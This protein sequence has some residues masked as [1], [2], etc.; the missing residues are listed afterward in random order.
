[1]NVNEE[2]Y[3]LAACNA[4]TSWIGGYPVT[5]SFSRTAINADSGAKSAI[6]TGIAAVT[7]V[8]VLMVFTTFLGELPIPGKCLKP[9]LSNFP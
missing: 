3:A 6:S 7:V 4:F 8:I 1:M 2:M 5:G 9:Q